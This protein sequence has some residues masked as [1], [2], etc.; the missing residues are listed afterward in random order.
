[1]TDDRR[2]APTWTLQMR[3]NNL[4][5]DS[6]CDQLQNIKMWEREV[7]KVGKRTLMAKD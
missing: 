7:I 3:K 1:M 6:I 4:V 5:V 2:E